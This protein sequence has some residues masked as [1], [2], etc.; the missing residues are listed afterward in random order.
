MEETSI[1]LLLFWNTTFY[2]FS[3]LFRFEQ[4]SEAEKKI[5]F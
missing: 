1:S 5:I 3:F 4:I 2:N